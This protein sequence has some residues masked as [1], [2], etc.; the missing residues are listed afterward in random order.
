MQL[1]ASPTALLAAHE[2]NIDTAHALAAEGIEQVQRLTTLHLMSARAATADGAHH[3]QAVLAAR[4]TPAFLQ[5]QA[6]SL[7]PQLEHGVAYLRGVSE[8]A[9]SAHEQFVAITDDWIARL[10]ES[11]TSAMSEASSAASAG[12]EAML[13]ALQSATDVAANLYDKIGESSARSAAPLALEAAEAE[14]TVQPAPRS[15]RTAKTTVP[16]APDDEG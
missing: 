5:A 14:K 11:L 15:S 2:I 3:A 13:V 1:K 16:A 4:N 6:D 10:K 9:S 7:E 8:I 12:P